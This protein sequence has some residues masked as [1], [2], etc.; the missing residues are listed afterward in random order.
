MLI[1]MTQQYVDLVLGGTKT[2]TI[3]PWPKC[4]LRPGATI[5]FNGRARATCTAIERR[6]LSDLSDADIYADGFET[7]D[8]FRTAFLS[9]YPTATDGTLVWI[10]R[11][12]LTVPVTPAPSR[13]PLPARHT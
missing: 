10:I 5:S 1:F 7:R 9:H 13:G 6:R 11:F 2:S 3:R 8:E 12:A 4:S